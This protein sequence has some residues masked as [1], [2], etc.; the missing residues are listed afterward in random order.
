M[1]L[2][3][4]TKKKLRKYWQNIQPIIL[5]SV[6]QE[7]KNIETKSE[8]VDRYIKYIPGYFRQEIEQ[9]FALTFLAC[10][11]FFIEYNKI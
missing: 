2:N 7:R 6:W 10:Y 4:K 9:T 11:I 1:I 5:P 3:D 8:A